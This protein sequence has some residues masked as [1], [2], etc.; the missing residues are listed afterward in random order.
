MGL[1]DIF[2][3]KKWYKKNESDNIWWLDNR[4]R[5]GEHIFSF[6]KRKKFNLFADYP[7]KLTKEQKEIFDR[8]NPYWK[9][10]FKDRVYKNDTKKQL[11]P[12]C[13]I[14]NN[15]VSNTII[16]ETKNFIIVPSKGALVSGYLLI[17]PK[18]HITSMNELSQSKK[19]ELKSLIFKY[20]NEFYNKFGKYP[21]IFEHGTS[22]QDSDNSSSSITHAHCHIVNHIFKNEK[23][24]INQLNLNQVDEN[25][26]F[27]DMQKSY[28]SYISPDLNF[29]ITYDFKS[30]SQQMRIFIAEDLDI[31]DKYNWKTSNFEDNIIE[32][33]KLFKN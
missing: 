33:I 6:N 32:T 14:D 9:N 25:S 13:N 31:Q 27:K 28:I 5:I 10:F 8:E 12:F 17:I 2:K 20:R 29:Y 15:D 24:I 11:C 1:F 3:K 22:K 4:D 19:E 18:N 21:I 23:D 26:F 30:K 7:Y 16:D